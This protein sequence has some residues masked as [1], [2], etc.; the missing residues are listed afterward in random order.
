MEINEL[1]QELDVLSGTGLGSI[2]LAGIEKA[3][4]DG[5]FYETELLKNSIRDAIALEYM[6]SGSSNAKAEKEAR[7]HPKY[8][9]YLRQK[10]SKSK[11]EADLTNN[12]YKQ[13]VKREEY[14][15]ISLSVIQSQMKNR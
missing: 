13:K 1:L 14:Y 2:Y 3:S 6:N 7:D 10:L 11:R 5:V 12:T 15:K 9:E 8:I 4:K